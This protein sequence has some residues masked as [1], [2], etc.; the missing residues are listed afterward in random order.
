MSTLVKETGYRNNGANVWFVEEYSAE[1]KPTMRTVW[2]EN[3]Q[4]QNKTE[5]SNGY[6][7]KY[8]SYRIDG[9]IWELYEYGSNGNTIRETTYHPSGSV[10]TVKNYDADG[11]AI[12]FTAYNQDGSVFIYEEY[13]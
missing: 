13:S 1:G 4:I 6:K 11:N 3:G 7:I 5:Y 10:F 9:S 12:D 8:T 2:Y